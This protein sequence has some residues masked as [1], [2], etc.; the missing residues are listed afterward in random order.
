MKECFICKKKLN[1]TDELMDATVVSF[2][3]FYFARNGFTTFIER[4]ALYIL[5]ARPNDLLESKTPLLQTYYLFS[6]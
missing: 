1:Q 5:I 6:L 2:F 3:K 4:V